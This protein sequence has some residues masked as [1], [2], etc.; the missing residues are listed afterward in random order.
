MIPS[1]HDMA[2]QSDMRREDLLQQATRHDQAQKRPATHTQPG[3]LNNA[4]GKLGDVM[5][6]VGEELQGRRGERRSP[7]DWQSPMTTDRSN[8]N[9][10][11]I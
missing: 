8:L 4:L 2:Q 5:V 11:C 1:Y 9:E 10:N 3:P 6:S 7:G